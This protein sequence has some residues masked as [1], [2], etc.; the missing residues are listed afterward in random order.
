MLG[1]VGQ[2]HRWCLQ[3]IRTLDDDQASTDPLLCKS[4]VINGSNKWDRITT[5]PKC[6]ENQKITAGAWSKAGDL[7]KT[8]MNP[9]CQASSSETDLN[10]KI[11]YYYKG[12]SS[13]KTKLFEELMEDYEDLDLE[14][15]NT[16]D[17]YVTKDNEDLSGDK[18]KYKTYK[19]Y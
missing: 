4:R 1:W 14:K 19:K 18:I 7:D 13:L 9:N 5:D 6:D 12:A 3:K 2:K 8:T 17:K 10:G 15:I 11:V 16:E